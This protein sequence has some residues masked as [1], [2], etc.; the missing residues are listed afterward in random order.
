MSELTSAS[1]PDQGPPPGGLSRLLDWA[2]RPVVLVVM[3]LLL[4][5]LGGLLGYVQAARLADVPP[6][7]AV[8]GSGQKAPATPARPASAPTPRPLD[9]SVTGAP[10]WPLW[11][12]QLDDALPA[13][14]P[15]LTPVDWKLLGAT[16]SNGR[17]EMVVLRQGKTEPEYFKVGDKLPGGLR[18]RDI[19][20]ENVTLV[21]GRR[22]IVLAYIGSR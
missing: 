4:G 18:V 16:L 5:A 7:A 19:T 1:A 22:E 8:T 20:Q 21:A 6:A 11:E 10:A 13:R 9:T 3:F 12:Y 15:P 14:D 17:W 2:G